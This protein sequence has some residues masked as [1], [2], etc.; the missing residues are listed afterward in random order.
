MHGCQAWVDKKTI[1]PTLRLLATR[2]VDSL[3]FVHHDFCK[4]T[5]LL[6]FQMY[7]WHFKHHKHHVV[8]LNV[9]EGG[10]LHWPISPKLS[11]LHQNNL[12]QGSPT[13]VRLRATSRRQSDMEG[14]SVCVQ[15]EC[16]TTE[17]LSVSIEHVW[18]T[19]DRRR[20]ARADCTLVKCFWITG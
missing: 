12:D 5:L 2:S 3:E 11:N 14:N 9:R 4:E 17:H 1:V 7:F 8:Q 19:G 13:S 18:L 16:N 15:E 20:R 10:N 6:S